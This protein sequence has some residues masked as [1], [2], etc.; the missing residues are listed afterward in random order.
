MS[1][2][3]SW[4][5]DLLHLQNDKGVDT[6]IHVNPPA[7]KYVRLSSEIEQYLQEQDEVRLS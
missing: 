3:A 2:L 6:I 5:E 1:H 7:D 4:S